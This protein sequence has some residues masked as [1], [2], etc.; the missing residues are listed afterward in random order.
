MTDGG[1]MRAKQS[2]TCEP[3]RAGRLSRRLK[4]TGWRAATA[5]AQA[6]ARM[7]A[8]QEQFDNGD[9]S[10]HIEDSGAE[11]AGHMPAPT[12]QA[13]KKCTGH[14]LGLAGLVWLA[15]ATMLTRVTWYRLT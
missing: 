8:A 3:P 9:G 10:V 5:I 4:A 15:L 11:A 2:L 13:G 12:F 1:R 7:S 6:K 14:R